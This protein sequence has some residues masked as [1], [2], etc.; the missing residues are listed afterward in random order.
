MSGIKL[1]TS[2]NDLNKVVSIT[3]ASTKLL[4]ESGTLGAKQTGILS[5]LTES[6]SQM[7]PASLEAVDQLSVAIQASVSLVNE[8]ELRSD[9]RV[10]LTTSLD[11]MITKVDAFASQGQLAN[12]ATLESLLFLV[13]NNIASEASQQM[14][15]RKRRSV[16]QSSAQVKRNLNL[17]MQLYTAI[18]RASIRGED[19]SVLS[20]KYGQVVLRREKSQLLNTTLSSDDCS[21]VLNKVLGAYSDV[22]QI[23]NVSYN[24]PFTKPSPIESKIAGLSYSMPNGTEIAV[25][26]LPDSEAI[27]I[28]LDGSTSRKRL[29]SKAEYKV[30]PAKGSV[31]GEILVIG[32]DVNATTLIFEIMSHGR[33]ISNIDAFV[34]SIK[35]ANGAPSMF[36][37]N[38]SK[39]GTLIKHFHAG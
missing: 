32:I 28:R 24:D 20:N 15:S 30:V 29:L 18:L 7:N 38:V 2:E 35:V 25:K 26:D 6:T 33:S 21:F 37:F 12:Q 16:S 23:F 31:E 34:S 13:Q 22:F 10:S 17:A 11:R 19:A 9:A 27:L 36:R 39:Q 5:T 8:A 1:L 3:Q 14:I 4:S